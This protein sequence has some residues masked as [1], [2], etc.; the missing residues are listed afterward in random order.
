ML[1]CLW[2]PHCPSSSNNNSYATL[3]KQY[4]QPISRIETWPTTILNDH[5]SSYWRAS[6]SPVVLRKCSICVTGSSPSAIRLPPPRGAPH[7]SS[8]MHSYVLVPQRR[9]IH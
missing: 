1:C 2:M 4:C 8:Q 6:T 3:F 5:A 7:H 9:C